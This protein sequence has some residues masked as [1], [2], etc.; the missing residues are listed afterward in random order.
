MGQRPGEEI[1]RRWV[2]VDDEDSGRGLFISRARRGVVGHGS[3]FLG[4]II[5]GRT[6]KRIVRIRN[7]I[8]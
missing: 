2:G 8:F 4:G 7:E 5:A 3:L 6:S 1:Q